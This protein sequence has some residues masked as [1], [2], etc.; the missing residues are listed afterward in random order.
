M[1]ML[2]IFYIDK[3]SLV[4]RDGCIYLFPFCIAF[5][6]FCFMV[7]VRIPHTVLNRSRESGQPRLGLSFRVIPFSSS[8]LV[9]ILK[10]KY[11]VPSWRISL[12]LLFQFAKGFNHEW[13]SNFVKCLFCIIWYSRVVFFCGLLLWWIILIDFGILN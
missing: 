7:L 12:P 5:L 13:L 8:L 4:N 6:F 11:S 9:A 3:H 10:S 1:F 2:R